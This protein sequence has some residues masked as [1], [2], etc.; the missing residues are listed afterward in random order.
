MPRSNGV[1]ACTAAFILVAVANGCSSLAG[2][3]A[4]DAYTFGDAAVVADG[5]LP[6][7]RDAATLQDAADAARSDAAVPVEASLADSATA[8]AATNDAT[9]SDSATVDASSADSPSDAAPD[10]GPSSDGSL[11]DGASSADAS[12]SVDAAASTAELGA[13]TALMTG[14]GLNNCGLALDDSCARSLLVPAGSFNRGNDPSTTASVNAF[15]LDKYEITVGRFRKFVDVWLNGWRPAVGAGKHRHVSGGQGL[16]A[17]Q[18]GSEAGWP[19]AWNAYVGAPSAAGE[20]PSSA[21]ASTRAAFD[22]ALGCEGA[23]AVWSATAGSGERRPMT[24]LSSYDAA[25]FC[26][27]DGGFLPSEAEWE[28]AAAGGDSQRT[29][30]W[31][32]ASPTITLASYYVDATRECMGDGVFGC[33]VADLVRAGSKPTGTG[34]WG[35]FEL[36]GNALEWVL[37]SYVAA[38]PATCTNCADVRPAALG[39]V[40]GGSFRTDAASMTTTKRV[41]PNKATRAADFGARC[42]RVP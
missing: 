40:R 19:S 10:G 34:R 4:K 9:V 17:V 32:S 8:D 21:G 14:D 11:V 12:A 30:P 20:V 27:W 37:D 31:G 5:S 35:Q 25:A 33:T 23:Y 26:I 3:D 42:A 41:A 15:R 6:P 36:A 29:Y 28:Y 16:A 38:Y 24:C 2:L 7:D 22:A 18:G 1:A 13:T 39:V